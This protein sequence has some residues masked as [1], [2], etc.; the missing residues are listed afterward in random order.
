VL[1]ATIIALPLAW[2]A[3]NKWLQSFAYRVDV[4]VWVFIA[5]GFIAVL[6]AFITVSIRSVKAAMANPAKSLKTD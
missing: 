1:L 5:A 2:F 4:H 6:I 3:M